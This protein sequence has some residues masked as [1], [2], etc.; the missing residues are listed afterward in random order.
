MKTSKLFK[1]KIFLFGFIIG[2]ITFICLNYY[3]IMLAFEDMCLHC[4]R[5]FGFPFY[6]YESGTI[7][8][9]EEITYSVLIINILIAITCSFLIGLIF[10]FV[11]S[12]ISARN[13]SQ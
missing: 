1:N 11:W 13:E 6:F 7:A 10:K 4:I 2:I 3:S 5:N 8:H 9:Y 12:K